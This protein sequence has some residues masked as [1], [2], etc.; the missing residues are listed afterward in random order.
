[1][2]GWN[3]VYQ[4][5]EKGEVDVAFLLAPIAMDLF[6]Y[7]VPVRLILFAHRDGSIFVAN[8][9]DKRLIHS[10]ESLR[11]HLEN[12]TF[13]VPH[14]LSIHHM[15]SDMFLKSLD[16]NP[17]VAGAQGVN[18][19]FEIVPPVQMPKFMASDE[20][21]GGFLVAEPIGTNAIY[22]NIAKPMFVSSEVWRDHPC[23][24]V[25]M[26]NELIEHHSDAVYE[27]TQMLVQAGMYI[28]NDTD[29]AAEIGVNFLDPEKNLGLSTKVLKKVL[30]DPKGIKTDNLFPV[31]E[32]LD[33][34]QR[35]M[36]SVMNIGDIIDLEKFVATQFAEE[37]CKNILAQKKSTM[38][39]IQDL[40]A[41][42]IDMYYDMDRNKAL[43]PEIVKKELSHHYFSKGVQ[44]L[45]SKRT[46][47]ALE[48][49]FAAFALDHQNMKAVNNIVV[50]Y[51]HLGSHDFA[52]KMVD[53]VLAI[54]PDNFR[55]QEHKKALMASAG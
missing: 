9:A 38:C 5:L 23:C 55:A 42:I 3:P 41:H 27:F 24:V 54:D 40:V 37:A 14:L 11:D 32:D 18:V 45:K 19:F 50:A 47:E 21:V 44:L 12:K 2:S 1:M 30:M 29:K 17:G 10:K 49:L 25:T 43:D 20:R 52:M 4:S 36:S 53:H 6:K 22:Q 16:L 15:L 48:S 34:I 46:F 28:S 51:K 31:L 7:D 39:D 35:Y 33:Q 26:R 8:N 13:Y